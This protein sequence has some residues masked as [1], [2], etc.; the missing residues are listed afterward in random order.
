VN[1]R[2]DIGAFE[3]QTALC[4]RPQGYWKN[5]PDEWPVDSLTLE[6]EEN[7]KA[8]L[9]AILNTPAGMG[10]NA[11]AS[12]ILAYQLIAAKLNADTGADTGSVDATIAAA[13]ALLRRRRV[14]D[15]IAM[16]ER[17]FDDLPLR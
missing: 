15:V 7:S 16:I 13:D 3:V 17:R 8:E 1:G 4:L 12:L 6:S 10:K 14:C 5:N 11:D 9:L 2:F